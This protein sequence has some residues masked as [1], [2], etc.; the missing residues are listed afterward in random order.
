[1]FKK[2]GNDLFKIVTKSLIAQEVHAQ[3]KSKDIQKNIK[4]HKK[5]MEERRKSFKFI[6]N[7]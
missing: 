3:Q 6:Q 1:M 7:K 2:H 4:D 5:V